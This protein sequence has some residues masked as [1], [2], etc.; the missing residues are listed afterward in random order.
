M[1]PTQEQA[2][3]Q[4]VKELEPVKMT[5]SGKAPTPVL[6]ITDIGRD[7]DDTIA[8]FVLRALPSTK[9]VGLVTTGG[10]TPK[11]A[12]QARAWLRCLGVEDGECQ[13]A[14]GPN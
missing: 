6:L 12:M 7:I 8:L 5:G 10:S 14:A 2:V 9:C 11:R 4:A 13:V 3:R 1:E